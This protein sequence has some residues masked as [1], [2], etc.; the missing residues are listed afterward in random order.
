[1]SF[2]IKQA[3]PQPTATK[4][5]FGVPRSPDMTDQAAK[6]GRLEGGLDGDVVDPK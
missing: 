3:V 4:Y 6:T 5:P 2:V 1:M